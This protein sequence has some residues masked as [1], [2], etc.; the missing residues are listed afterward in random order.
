MTAS[1]GNA[2]FASLGLTVIPED[3]MNRGRLDA[4]GQL[5]PLYQ[6]GIIFDEVE[7]KVVGW[8][9]EK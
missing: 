7:R 3:V 2:C 9:V 1:E 8:D 6:I 4:A 5:L